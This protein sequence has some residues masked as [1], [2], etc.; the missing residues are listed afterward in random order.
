MRRSPLL[1]GV[2]ITCVAGSTRVSVT[3]DVSRFA[4]TVGAAGAARTTGAASDANPLQ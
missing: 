3:T 1:L 2:G 4:G